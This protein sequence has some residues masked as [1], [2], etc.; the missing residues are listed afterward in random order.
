MS[1]VYCSKQHRTQHNVYCSKQHRTQHNVYASTQ[2]KNIAGTSTERGTFGR[3]CSQAA[4][5]RL[6]NPKTEINTL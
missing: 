5:H 3:S 1:S 2:V 6:D 4:D